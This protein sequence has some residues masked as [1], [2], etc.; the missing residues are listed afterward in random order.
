M[1]ARGERKHLNRGVLLLHFLL[2][3]ENGPIPSSLLSSKLRQEGIESLIACNSEP[4]LGI[5]YI[6]ESQQRMSLN[7]RTEEELEEILEEEKKW[8]ER[9]NEGDII[10]LFIQLLE[11]LLF[12]FL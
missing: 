5:S 3:E 2:L 6:Y 9:K 7:R 4:F 10:L 1:E 12:P 11:G 8:E